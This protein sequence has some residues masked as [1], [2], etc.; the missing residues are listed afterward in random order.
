MKQY[1]SLGIAA[2]AVKEDFMKKIDFYTTKMPINA[3]NTALF[4]WSR[5]LVGV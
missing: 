2:I 1:R 3:V 5:C 4:K